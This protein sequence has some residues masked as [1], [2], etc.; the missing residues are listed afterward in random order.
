LYIY[1]L[2]TGYT[3]DRVAWQL[4]G[5]ALDIYWYAIC[6]VVGMALG[7][8]VVARVARERALAIWR[9]T[10]PVEVR[11][12][13]LASLALPEEM[14]HI[15]T[16]QNIHTVGDLLLQW[17]YE[18]RHIGLNQAGLDVV[19][20]VL[21]AVP[22]VPES[23]LHDAPWRIWNPEHVW[24]GIG[25]C[26]VLAVIGARLYHVFTPSP[27]MAAVGIESPLDYF[28]HPDQ[29]FNLRNGGLG[30]YGGLAGGLLGLFIYTRRQRIPLL[31]WADLC[32]L[33]LSLGQVFGRW[34]NFFNQ[35]LYG[36]PTNV[37]W[38]VH[39]EPVYRLP[40]DQE[41]SRFHPAFLYESLWSLLTFA[42]L[43]FLLRRWRDKLLPGD[44][45][46]VYLIAYGI[47]R[48]LLEL[49]RLDSRTLTIGALEITLSVATL[50]SL[51]V[52][53]AMVIWLV[54][55]HQSHRT[56]LRA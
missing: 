34:G 18:P 49:V 39:I 19:R 7:A 53:M 23:W 12:R 41:F 8:F 10:V 16:K 32:T 6:I 22:D 43:F 30:I 56:Q 51:I 29:L 42:V 13:P 46:A 35:E 2:T 50:V 40:A 36:R 48:S 54:L 52:A 55:K 17:G 4:P 33:G 45:T 20:E 11:E 3:P 9:Q 28:R 38:A 37:F 15:L 27:S 26:L 1:H 25:W 24:N 31:G 44:M 47:G 5:V 21:L 14:Q